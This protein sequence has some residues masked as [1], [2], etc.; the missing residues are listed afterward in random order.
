MRFSEDVDVIPRFSARYQGNRRLL[1]LS[2]GGTFFQ[3]AVDGNVSLKYMQKINGQATLKVNA[4]FSKEWLQETVDEGWG[5][6]LYDYNKSGAGIELDLRRETIRGGYNYYIMRFPNYWTLASSA[7]TFNLETVGKF[8][9]DYDANE[10]FVLGSGMLTGEI[11]YKYGYTYTRLDYPWQNL[12]D[13]NGQYIDIKRFD[14]IHCGTV[15]LNWFFPEKIAGSV[16][17]EPAMSLAYNLTYNQ[18]NQNHYDADPAR[19]MP[20]EHY[21]DYAQSRATASYNIHF[22]PSELDATAAFTYIYKGYLNRP[23]Q[24]SDGEYGTE[25]MYQQSASFSVYLD[26]PVWDYFSIFLSAGANSSSSNNKYET[27]YTYNY[28]SANYLL[29]IS[30]KY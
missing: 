20:V 5:L 26:Y 29:G 28:T 24:H 1:E 22:Y 3:Q 11:M 6:G 12:V 30:F 23:L 2:G 27:V 25:K 4:G 7:D 18:S 16:S 8:V 9:L 19:L 14:N 21:Y 10:I 13:S 17:F 15:G